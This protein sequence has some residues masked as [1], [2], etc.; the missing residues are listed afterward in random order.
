MIAKVLINLPVL[1]VLISLLAGL[2]YSW[3]LYRK[4]Q[5]DSGPK[6][7]APA[8]AVARFI[9]VALMVW[10]LFAPSIRRNITEVQKPALVILQDNSSSV[11]N[12]TDEASREEYWK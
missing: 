5:F 10:L 6:W 2:L 9:V 8:L 1:S 11:T 3:L 12:K 7:L 4:H